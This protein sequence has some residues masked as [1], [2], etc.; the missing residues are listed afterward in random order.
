[1]PNSALARCR[2]C[3]LEQPSPPW[4]EDG[5]TPSYEYCPCCG[6]EFGY[7]DASLTGVVRQRESWLAAGGTWAEPAAMPPRW[8]LD[9]QLQAIPP[10][11]RGDSEVDEA[12]R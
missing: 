12:P 7:Q 10:E 5:R 8:K 3:G 1:M 11:W 4:G 6:T 9:E 2:V